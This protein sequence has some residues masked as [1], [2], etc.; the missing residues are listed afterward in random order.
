MFHSVRARLT[1][2]Y[3]AVVAVV[4][5]TFSIISYVLLS[6]AIRSATDATLAATGRE[7]ASAFSKGDETHSPLDFRF[8]DREIRVFFR[9]GR[10]VASSQS[11]FTA[12]EQRRLAALAARPREG[13][14]TIEGGADG[15]GIRVYTQP[16]SVV[17][18]SFTVMVAQDLDPQADRL[19]NAARAVLLGIPI[20]MLVAAAGGYLLA[21][22]SLAPVTAMSE[23]A[24]Q[25]GAATLNERIEIENERD[26]L[27]HLGL[28]L[29]DLLGRLE[30]A[31]ESQRQFMTDASH[32][33]RTPI[34]IILG[35][36]DVALSRPERARTEYRESIRI[37]R[38]AALKLTRIVQNVFLLARTDA[39]SYPISKTRF[40]LD[41]L[42]AES[43]HA[44]RSVAAAKNIDV[45]CETDPD[46]ILSAD[47][48]LIQHLMQNLIDNALKFT[49]G[50]GRVVISA[51]S[52]GTTYIV[53]VTDS[54]SGISPADQPFIFDRFFRGRRGAADGGAG[55]GLA[56]GRW[57]A[58]AHGAVLA[59]ERSDAHGTTFSVTFPATEVSNLARVAQQE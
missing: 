52:T 44:T 40:Y 30:R 43:V 36:A 48:E 32:E 2:W 39:G 16:I 27:G 6:R 3:T 35:E 31:F 4:L 25:I 37:M 28:T 12:I 51:R 22:K 49:P 58:E 34:S 53:R 23:K 14:V 9:D 59:L 42:L 46:L 33:L 15:D 45:R 57:I 54:G 5:I 21:R 18:T 11:R 56:I 17:G 13:F 38:K 10:V 26:E 24:R 47:E 50:G 8:S 55:L 7:F 19:E 1:L 20:A 41:E 29:N